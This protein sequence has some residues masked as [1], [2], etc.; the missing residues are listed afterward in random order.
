MRITTR[1][2][3]L[4]VIVVIVAVT[5]TTGF[6]LIRLHGE[7]ARQA[8]AAQESRLKT[9][10]GFLKIKGN[11]F[12][13]VEGKLLVDSYVIS[14][15]NEIPDK[16]QEIFGGTATIF[17]GDTRVATNVLKPDGSRAV[18][19]KL[20]GPAYDA[21]F[22]EGKS[23]RG[24]AP[25]LDDIYL[26]AYDPIRNNKGETIGGLYVGTKKSDYFAEYDRLKV[27]TLVM[28]MGLALLLSL[29]AGILVRRTLRPL[30]TMVATLKEITGD[31]K[32][33]T[34]LDQRL[35]NSS[36]DEIGETGEEINNLLG[37]MHQIMT[38]VANITQR[39]DSHSETI[40]ETIDR[41]TGFA[42][43]LSSSVVEISTTMEEFSTSASLIAHHSQG[44]AEIGAKTLQDT[45][46][47]ADGVETLTG[48]MDEIRAHNEAD[49]REI[50][51]LGRKSKEI[52]KIMV[53]IN[54][55]A[56]QTKLIAFNAALEAA[57]AG[58]A[59]KRFGVVAV[60]IRRLAD[61]VVA[62]TGEIEGKVTEIMDTV[63]RL[64]LAS[65]KSSREIREGLDYAQ[66]TVTMLGDVVAGAEETAEAGKQIS[67]STQQ[68]QT[69]STQV[70]IALRD[71]E[72]GTRHSSSAMQQINTI[73]KDLTELADELKVLVGKF[74]LGENRPRTEA[75]TTEL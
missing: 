68:Q 74:R 71:I 7:I 59:G 19:T 30:K 57:S 40:A 67:L 55:I 60:E 53:I 35:D 26:T 15:N 54:N 51:E 6:A 16:I 27:S 37:K 21:I 34:L 20:V 62:S 36:S 41:Q 9:F 32:N 75:E 3:V 73:A 38:M 65:E 24:E 45:K 43:Q 33:L 29:L 39:I 13:I 8:V 69:A 11:D 4:Y 48:K 44:V 70:V 52:T 56:N 14:E 2:I 50:V 1:F 49:L 72:E 22:K 47:G 64:V 18:G 63:N 46:A 25:I 31:D 10:W 66:Q 23:Y 58:E 42:T 17:M 28:M 61:N 12:R 5:I